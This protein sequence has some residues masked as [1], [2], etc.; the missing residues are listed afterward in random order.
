MVK[1]KPGDVL[2]EDVP[3]AHALAVDQKGKRCDFCLEAR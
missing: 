1:I 2:C 3:F